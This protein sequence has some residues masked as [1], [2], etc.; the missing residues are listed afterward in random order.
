MPS[1]VAPLFFDPALHGEQTGWVY[2]F[3]TDS[4]L[5]AVTVYN[6]AGSFVGTLFPL[7]GDTTALPI[8]VNADPLPDSFIDS[9]SA[10]GIFEQYPVYTEFLPSM[11]PLSRIL[12]G[13]R[14]KPIPNAPEPEYTPVWILSALDTSGMYRLTCWCTMDGTSRGCGINMEQQPGTYPFTAQEGLDISQMAAGTEAQPCLVAAGNVDTTGRATEWNYAFRANEGITLIRTAGLD[15]GIFNA[16]PVPIDTN[17]VNFGLVYWRGTP[18]PQQWTGSDAALDRMRRTNAFIEHA[19]MIFGSDDLETFMV[20][21]TAT[22]QFEAYSQVPAGTHVWIFSA[23]SQQAQRQLICWCSMDPA[24]TPFEE[25]IGLVSGS[26]PNQRSVP[27]SVAPNPARDGVLVRTDG[28]H[29]IDRVRVVAIDGRHVSVPMLLV[30]HSAVWM[31]TSGLSVGSYV[32]LVEAG[33]SQYRQL[34]QVVR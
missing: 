8:Y 14:L 16:T 29:P 3:R 23:Q 32:V 2:A 30:G 4:G 26:A 25:C 34:L 5:Q 27:I 21:G 6:I 31:D 18:F 11:N 7:P 13:G 19:P 33:R 1:A 12:I 17:V 28:D 9:D 15:Q 10:V 20:G 24:A 22:P